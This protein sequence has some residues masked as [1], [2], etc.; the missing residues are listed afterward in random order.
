M[1]HRNH[2]VLTLCHDSL[3]DEDVTYSGAYSD[4]VE[5]IHSIRR[6]LLHNRDF[7]EPYLTLL[8]DL[9]IAGTS[10]AQ[11]KIQRIQPRSPTDVDVRQYFCSHWPEVRLATEEMCASSGAPLW[12]F[13]YGGVVAAHD[14]AIH[15]NSSLIS[16][17]QNVGNSV[18]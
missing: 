4:T 6:Q 16:H 18:Q 15:V 10:Q 8:Q 11:E 14:N 7:R 9:Y 12:G 13:T 3:Q 1:T 17:L 2:V 5:L